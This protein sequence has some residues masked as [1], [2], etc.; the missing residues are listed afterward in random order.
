MKA[1]FIV[2][3]GLEKVK[4]TYIVPIGDMEKALA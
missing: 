2:D 1:F 4:T 3:E